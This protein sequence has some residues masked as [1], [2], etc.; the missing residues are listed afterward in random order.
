MRGKDKKHGKAR[1][2]KARFL[3]RSGK[4][5]RGKARS[6]KDKRGK[7]KRGKGRRGKRT[8]EVQCRSCKGDC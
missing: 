1:S 3:A 2:G 5:K 4:D 8:C 6:G 7:V